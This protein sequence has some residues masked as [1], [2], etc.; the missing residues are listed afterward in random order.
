MRGLQAEVHGIV[1]RRSVCPGLICVDQVWML[2]LDQNKKAGP[3]SPALTNRLYPL[4][5]LTS[6]ICFWTEGPE[7]W[8]VYSPLESVFTGMITWLLPPFN[9]TDAEITTLPL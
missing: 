9:E 1:E 4:Y 5:C 8:K 7:S 2:P 6:C 3:G